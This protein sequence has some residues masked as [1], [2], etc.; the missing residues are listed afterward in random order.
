M[1]SYSGEDGDGECDLCEGEETRDEV[2][3]GV[4]RVV[5]GEVGQ[6]EHQHSKQ[7]TRLKQT[8]HNFYIV[9]SG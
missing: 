4:E 8:A 3:E 5:V 7:D 1:D 2:G 9:L 6:T